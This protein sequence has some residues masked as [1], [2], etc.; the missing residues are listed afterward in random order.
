MKIERFAHYRALTISAL[1]AAVLW[2]FACSFYS[3]AINHCTSVSI[4]W[5]K[6]GVSPSELIRQQTYARQDGAGNQPEATLWQ[7]YPEQ[8]IMASDKKK[9]KADVVDVFGDCGDIVSS[10]LTAGAYPARSDESGCAVSTG[11]AFSLWGSTNVIGMPVKVEGKQF[12]VRGIFEEEEPRLFLQ[13]QADSEKLLSNMQ[14]T[15]TGPGARERTNQYLSSAGF[16]EGRILDLTLFAWVLGM[17]FRLPAIILAFGIL[18]RVI[19]YGKRLCHYPILLAIYLLMAFGILAGL[20]FCIDLPK[21]PSDFIPAM[22]SDFGFWGNLF[23]E[24]GKNMVSWMTAGPAFRDME[25]WTSSFMAVLLSVC[26]SA[27]TAAAAMLV[28]IR[29]YKRMI[30]FCMAYTLTI[31]LISFKIASVHNMTFCKAM[32]L[33]PCLWICVDF[34]FYYLKETVAAADGEGRVLDE[35]KT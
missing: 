34:L 14:L 20:W 12:Y 21:F 11:L 28:S 16:P 27:F 29:S 33:M 10:M 26:A 22:W 3:T 4:K 6:G 9:M 5:E 25:L 31:C 30:F 32:Y 8:E 15:F 1:L 19:M 23:E 24:Q 13:A 35:E 2:C 17:I 18:G 7:T